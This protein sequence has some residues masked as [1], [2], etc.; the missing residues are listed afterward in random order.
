MVSGRQLRK[1]NSALRETHAP[2]EH[3]DEAA[4]FLHPSDAAAAGVA[5]GTTVRVRSAAGELTGRARTDES[6][7]QGAVWV[8]HGWPELNVGRLTSERLDVDPLTGM[9]VQT[10]LPV[11]I[12]AGS[13]G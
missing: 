1:M 13:S 2:G 5:E 3:V 12:E 7:R 8:P 4:I 9:V 11:S 6:I 10:G